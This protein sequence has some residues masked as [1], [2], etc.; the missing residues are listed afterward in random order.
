M[1]S[2]DPED[3]KYANLQRIQQRMA[4]RKKKRTAPRQT[5]FK[6][7]KKLKNI[8]NPE[9]KAKFEKDRLEKEKAIAKKYKEDMK[10]KKKLEKA[11]KEKEGKILKRKWKADAKINKSGLK[12]KPPDIKQWNKNFAKQ[13]YETQ[14]RI[15]EKYE[16]KTRQ[17]TIDRKQFKEKA[18]AIEKKYD[19]KKPKKKKRDPNKKIVIIDQDHNA[20]TAVEHNDFDL[21]QRIYAFY[22]NDIKRKDKQGNTILHHTI[23]H[24]ERT[25]NNNAHLIEY[26]IPKLPPSFMNAVN[27]LGNTP[28]TLAVYERKLECMKALYSGPTKSRPNLDHMNINGRTV[29]MHAAMRDD[30]EVI[31]FLLQCNPPPSMDLVADKNA[32]TAL[33]YAVEHGQ[34]KAVQTLVK[35]GANFYIKNKFGKSARGMA[36][37]KILRIILDQERV[38]AVKGLV[39]SSLVQ[40]LNVPDYLITMIGQYLTAVPQEV[41]D[42]ERKEREAEENEKKKKKKG[43]K[44]KKKKKKKNTK[45]R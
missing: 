29:L 24:Y 10:R 37:K 41:L 16:A 35:N 14:M 11:K 9:W 18:A 1:A 27:Y 20:F 33:T 6:K 26:L 2:G 17:D 12:E 19:N 40:K 28:M 36:T 15:N 4:A 13:Q 42:E 31:Q 3:R 43:K 30:V 44:G 39:A 8:E 34:T 45:A 38:N 22:P 23:R 5:E 7:K 25:D 21:L 32:K